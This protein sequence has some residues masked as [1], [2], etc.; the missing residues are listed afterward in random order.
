MII[1]TS[2]DS[3]CGVVDLEQW[4]DA[5]DTAPQGLVRK[6]SSRLYAL[7]YYR[8]RQIAQRV[9]NR[10]LSRF[11]LRTHHLAV[12]NSCSVGRI[13]AAASRRHEDEE[14][15]RGMFATLFQYRTETWEGRGR[16]PSTL[17][18]LV[19]GDVCLLN[20]SIHLGNPIDWRISHHP[21][22]AYLWRFQLHYHEFLLQVA[23]EQW[24]D[25]AVRGRSDGSALDEAMWQG[26]L[27]T[28]N[29]WIE[30]NPMDSR[31]CQRDAW[32]PYCISR[33]IPVWLLLDAAR[34]EAGFGK[35]EEGAGSGERIFDSLYAQAEYLAEHLEWDLGG[36]H[37]LENIKAVCLAA[38]AFRT[39]EADRWLEKMLPILRGELQK[40]VLPHGEHY[41]RSPMYHCQILGNLLEM[42]VVSEKV[43]Q[44]LHRLCLEYARPMWAFLQGILHPDGEIPLFA[45]S[46]FGEAPSVAYI[47]RLAEHLG[48]TPVGRN[49]IPSH[50]DDSHATPHSQAGEGTGA[51]EELRRGG[52]EETECHSVLRLRT[53]AVR[54]GPLTL[55]LSP[56][57]WLR[58]FRSQP[59]HEGEGTKDVY[60]TFRYGDDFLIFDRG[61]AGT[62]ELPAHAHCDLLTLE[63][64]FGGQRVIVDSGLYN[65]SDDSMRRYVRSS[66]AH[67]VVTVDH[68]NQCDVW[69]SFRMGYRGWTT[70]GNQGESGGFAW[71]TAHHSAYRRHGVPRMQRLVA[72]HADRI[73]VCLDHAVSRQRVPWASARRLMGGDRGQ[74]KD[75][76]SPHLTGYLHFAPSVSLS[77]IAA[78]HFRLETER[79]ELFLGLLDVGSSEVAAGWYCPEFG[80][81]LRAPVLVYSAEAQPFGWVISEKPFE[82]RLGTGVG[83]D[84]IQSRD[85]GRSGTPSH[86]PEAEDHLEI[87]FT[88]AGHQCYRMQLEWDCD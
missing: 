9:W 26:L 44:P 27:S 87:S 46:C 2:D 48:I 15:A 43:S 67:N 68:Q 45:D 84:A 75:A 35:K 63:A 4:A 39:E 61:D 8:K 14:A 52:G 38:C 40:Q 71:A 32:H 86:L 34:R 10:A 82:C 73:W 64:S 50:E 18:I 19:S 16:P 81:R 47:R 70:V 24:A 78:D 5:R 33:R 72:G 74:Q 49:A 6:V 62:D 23:M 54:L 55:T 37:L 36:N 80:R 1:S 58:N 13:T 30:K 28:L 25:S 51:L 20:R 12:A 17:Q 29:D 76:N 56:M 60:W 59:K 77:R 85:V 21:N 88:G 83:R 57:L 42:A 11:R 66:E 79:G 41:E 31:A 22:V 69:S 53:W 3:P 65:Y 7:H